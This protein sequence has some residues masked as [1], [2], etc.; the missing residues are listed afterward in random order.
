ML[1]TNDERDR[2]DVVRIHDW[3]LEEL[4]LVEDG[5]LTL[6]GI[7][8]LVSDEPRPLVRSIAVNCLRMAETVLRSCDEIE[9]SFPR[10]EFDSLLADDWDETILGPLLG[11]LGFVTIYPDSV[12]PLHERI[13]SALEAQG[14]L[15]EGTAIA[16]AYSRLLPQVVDI[17]NDRCLQDIVER[18]T[19]TS[20]NET[21]EV[22]EAVATLADIPPVTV[23][24]PELEDAIDEQRKEYEQE[25]QVLRSLLAPPTESTLSRVDTSEPIDTTA[26]PDVQFDDGREFLL[27]ILTTIS[28]HPEFAAFDLQ[29]VTDRLSTTPYAVYQMLS[30]VPGIDCEVRDDGVIVFSSIPATVDGNDLREE[31]TDHLIERC[32]S[33]QRRI[34]ALSNA[35]LSS[36]PEAVASDQIVAEDYGSLDD[37]DVAPAY[38]I[39]TLVDP[40]ALGE[41]KMNAYVGESRGLGRERAQLRRWHE[42]RSSGL[43]S[44]TSMT[45]RLFSLGIERDLENKVLR[46]MTPFDDDT[47]NEYV[48]QIRRLL[49]RGFELRLLTRHT[50]EPWE[51]RRL[52]R[53]LLSEI[54]NHR[55][56][57]TVRT[58]SRFKEHQRVRPDTDFRD[59]GEFGIHG[60]LQTIG[61]PGE[62]A[63]LLGS[64]NFMENSYDWNPECG[65][66]TER[67][68]FVDAA[69]EFF[70]IVWEAS[71]ADELSIERL[72]EIPDRQL[73]PT[74]YS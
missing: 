55:D 31:Y 73:V 74:Y 56:R 4:N 28:R 49:E 34:D 53:N 65:V 57:V 39:Y 14:N 60:K 20:P 35:S 62:G 64:A 18:V 26:I 23:E 69:I 45:D 11:S 15:T 58:Y 3:L 9:E 10:R 27:N 72:Q 30:A 44:Y 50:K 8:V 24:L 36:D 47:F 63:A 51:W 48:S 17:E 16:V 32:S 33:V 40:D 61:Y 68:Q 70:D 12:E 43:R 71:E 46:I 21:I 6:L 25:F 54:K 13:D 38:F 52:Q 29:F 2:E 41:K 22:V 7:V 19:G 5:E 42:N 59:V 66:Y 37:G 67:T 1:R